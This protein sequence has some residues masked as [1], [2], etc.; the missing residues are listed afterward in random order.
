MGDIKKALNMLKKIA[1][2]SK[3]FVEAKKKQ[4]DIYLSQLRDRNN[5]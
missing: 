2:E 1:P 5:Y 4:A 3:N